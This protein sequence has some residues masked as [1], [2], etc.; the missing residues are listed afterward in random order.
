[1]QWLRPQILSVLQKCREDFTFPMLDNGYVY[2]AATRLALYCS[3]E[4]WALTIEVFGFSP[5]SGIPDIQIYTFGSKL[6]RSRQEEDFV[7]PEAYRSYLTNNPNNDSVFVYPIDEGDW[8]D[9]DDSDLLAETARAISVRGQSVSLPPR[10]EYS[11]VGIALQ[12]ESRIHVF[13]LCRLLAIQNRESVLATP[14]ERRICVPPELTQI[15]QLEEWHHP[16]LAGEET[17]HD[18]VTFAALA[19]A[20]VS[21][22]ASEFKPTMPPNTHWRHWPEGGTL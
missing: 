11:R 21:G 18:S 3:A 5:R 10:H 17:I 6:V 14:E 20:L 1:M 8:Q 2:L 22:K 19:D 15:L 13:E 7:N 16:D 4:D 12:D 9:P